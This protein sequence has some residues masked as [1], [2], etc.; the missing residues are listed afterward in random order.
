[1]QSTPAESLRVQIIA[2]DGGVPMLNANHTLTLRLDDIN[3]FHPEFEQPSYR[4][5]AQ[6]T[7]PIQTYLIQVTAT[8]RDGRDN[9]ISY[10]LVPNVSSG[11]FS[12]DANGVI[13]N[14]MLLESQVSEDSYSLHWKSIY[15]CIIIIIFADLHHHCC[16][17]GQRNARAPECHS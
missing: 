15:S 8:D 12:I 6:N 7:A 16:C 11:N 4:I 9:I 2:E 5:S 3:E 14:T 13:R 17:Y 1:M 10:D